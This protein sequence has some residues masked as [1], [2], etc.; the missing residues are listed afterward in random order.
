MTLLLYRS[1]FTH[2]NKD[3]PDLEAVPDPGATLALFP[4]LLQHLEELP[5]C[6]LD[7]AEVLLVHGDGGEV[8]VARQRVRLAAAGGA[9]RQDGKVV[10]WETDGEIMGKFL[11]SGIP[12]I[13]K[14]LFK[15]YLVTF[16]HYFLFFH[17]YSFLDFEL[18]KYPCMAMRKGKVALGM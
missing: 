12:D 9:V 14:L 18:G 13:E 10:P 3:C 6:P 5:G 16:S 15:K 17:F 7:L 2:L 4:L 1:S 11:D 8:G